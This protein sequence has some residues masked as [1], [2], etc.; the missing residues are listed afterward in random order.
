MTLTLDE[1]TARLLLERH[2]QPDVL[3]S[4]DDPALLQL[5]EMRLDE[6]FAAPL[7]VLLARLRAA[8]EAATVN[9]KAEAAMGFAL[10]IWLA[11]GI[12]RAEFDRLE[13]LV[14]EAAA[15]AH[16][17]LRHDVRPLSP[18][19]W[20]EALRLL[21]PLDNGCLPGFLSG[22]LN[23]LCGRVQDL[24]HIA[25]PQRRRLQARRDH[26]LVAC[27]TDLGLSP[28][29]EASW[30]AAIDQAAIGSPADSGPRP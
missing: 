4:V 9:G 21:P 6:R 22:G 29:D 15:R 3:P 7:T 12:T 5:L 11:G 25:D 20:A 27:L 24:S 30:R 26:A 19:D 2:G 10:G 13:R 28:E 1:L 8:P 16:D 17:R 14:Y 23:V 18:A